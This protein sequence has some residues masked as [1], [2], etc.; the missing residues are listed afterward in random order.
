MLLRVPQ[1][2]LATESAESVVNYELFEPSRAETCK[3]IRVFEGPLRSLETESAENLVNYELFEPSK[4]E[5]S[6]NVYVLV[7]VHERLRFM[8]CS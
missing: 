2:S 7:P 3:N 8:V 1:R 5:T 6:K 4:A